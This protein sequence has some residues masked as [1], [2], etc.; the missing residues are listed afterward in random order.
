MRTHL[1][2]FGFI[3]L[4]LTVSGVAAQ[5]PLRRQELRVKLRR[6]ERQ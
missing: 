4:A 1:I 2:G 6:L 5:E 3:A